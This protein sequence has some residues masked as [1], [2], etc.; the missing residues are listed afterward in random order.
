[1]LGGIFWGN[2]FGASGFVSI[3]SYL[4]SIFIGSFKGA[5]VGFG[6]GFC[7]SMTFTTGG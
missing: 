4:S 6:S 7:S 1:L 3:T 5:G 2:G